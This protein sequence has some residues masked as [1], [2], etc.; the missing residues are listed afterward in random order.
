MGKR[1]KQPWSRENLPIGTVRLRKHSKRGK[2]RM[3]KVRDDGPRGGRWI[4]FAR[5]W[6]LTNK[7]PI[8]PG[9]RVVHWDGDLLNDDPSNYR[10]VTADDV[11]ILSRVWDPTLDERNH[12][13]AAQGTSQCNRDRGRVNRARRLLIR[14]WYAVDPTGRVIINQP[15]R[16]R[17]A[18]ARRYI[19]AAAELPA[20]GLGISAVWLGWPD[21]TGCEAEVL[22]ALADGGPAQIAV[23]R[24]RVG[25]VRRVHGWGAEPTTSTCHHAI[26]QLRRRRSNYIESAPTLRR[27][28]LYTIAPAALAARR[29][30]C[31]L[32]A[33]RGGEIAT[34]FPDFRKVWPEE[35]R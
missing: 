9:M 10:L 7:G 35:H 21:L 4:A 23:I 11:L 12:E 27:R 13:R 24:E 33:V 28:S 5:Y 31:P 20:N 17:L 25:E 34:R 3:I 19:D 1:G 8:P 32:V 15:H 26:W 18:I 22:A 2:V 29:E 30:P 16:S 6:W 14:H